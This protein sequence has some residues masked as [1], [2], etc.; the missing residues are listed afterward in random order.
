[1]FIFSWNEER[2]PQCKH[3]TEANELMKSAVPHSCSE[4]T[5]SITT[6]P[7]GLLQLNEGS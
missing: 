7:P 6:G 1:M 5:P 4:E 3:N 2:K